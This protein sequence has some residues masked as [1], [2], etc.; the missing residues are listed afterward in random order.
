MIRLDIHIFASDYLKGKKPC[1]IKTTEG[2]NEKVNKHGK[3]EPMVS[4]LEE[5]TKKITFLCKTKKDTLVVLLTIVCPCNYFHIRKLLLLSMF[6]LLIPRLSILPSSFPSIMPVSRFSTL[7]ISVIS[8]SESSALSAS[9][10]FMLKSS[11]LFVFAVPVSISFAPSASVLPVPG[12]SALLFPSMSAIFVLRSFDS[13]T[14]AVPMSRLFAPLF[15]S[16]STILVPSFCALFAL[17]VL[18]LSSFLFLFV[19]TISIPRLS[20]SFFI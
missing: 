1:F 12:S 4:N 8:M 17:I 9:V 6:S 5:K 20:P 19:F 7:F 14:F 10:I 11:T 3:E 13:Y 2:D 15:L 16:A 18:K